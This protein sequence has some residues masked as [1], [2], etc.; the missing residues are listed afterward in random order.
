MSNK[1]YYAGFVFSSTFLV[2]NLQRVLFSLFSIETYA[3]PHLKWIH[4]HK[5]S[6][7]CLMALSLL[8]TS[9]LF[10]EI[11]AGSALSLII[12]SISTIL[13]LLY[14]YQ[15]K[16]SRLRDIPH[17]KIHLIAII[18]VTAVGIFPLINEGV[19]DLNNW[20]FVVAHYLYI[21][22]ITIPFDIRDLK[23]DHRKLRTF[24]QLIGVKNS[25]ILSVALLLVFAGLAL[26]FKETLQT[27]SIF[28]LALFLTFF[29]LMGIHEKRH[30]FYCSGWIESSIILVGWS[31]L[32]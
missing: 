7:F 22:A 32:C 15:S 21:V 8:C 17:L 12:L 26:F 20:F 5:I 13:S 11:Y 6:T 23:Y 1:F 31:Y 16:S 25:K 18:W 30:S 2:Y 14:V 3:S 19:E 24:P 9:F 10:I 28:L 4:T 29:L 27:N